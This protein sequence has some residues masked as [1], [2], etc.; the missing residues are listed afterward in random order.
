[1]SK[2]SFSIE[3]L[4]HKDDVKNACV[5][6]A[7]AAIDVQKECLAEHPTA[8]LSPH[9]KGLVYA[10]DPGVYPVFEFFGFNF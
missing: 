4:W 3:T 10:G 8:D 9:Y 5:N 7:E 6:V 2:K 1:M